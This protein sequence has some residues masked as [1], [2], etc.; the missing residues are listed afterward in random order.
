MSRTKGSQNKHDNKVLSEAKKLDRQGFDVKADVSGFPQPNTLGGYRPDIIATK[1]NQRK[2]IE[3]ETQESKDSMR[4]KKQQQMFRQVAKR[5][6]NT[7][8]RRIVI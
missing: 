5:S 4:D 7:T 2:I 6:K 3:V 8:F 1:A